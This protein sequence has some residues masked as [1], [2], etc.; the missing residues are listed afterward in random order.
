MNTAAAAS[1]LS[2]LTLAAVLTLCMLVGV[3]ALAVMDSPAPQLAQASTAR[4]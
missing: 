1:R 3:N 2:S 4:A